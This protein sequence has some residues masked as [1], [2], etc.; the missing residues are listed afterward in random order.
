MVINA[1]Y[2]EKS[3]QEEYWVRVKTMIE[4]DTTVMKISCQKM[5]SDSLLPSMT[6][7]G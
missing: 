7:K 4:S 2:L 5:Q 3:F 6:L 1:E